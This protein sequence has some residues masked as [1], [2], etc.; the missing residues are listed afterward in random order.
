MSFTPAISTNASP[1]RLDENT[2]ISTLP[3]AAVI[4]LE[5]NAT[6]MA[7]KLINNAYVIPDPLPGFLPEEMTPGLGIQVPRTNTGPGLDVEEAE[8][9]KH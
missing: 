3:P 4:P 7:E 5:H 1:Q 8:D 2:A 6:A 9:K